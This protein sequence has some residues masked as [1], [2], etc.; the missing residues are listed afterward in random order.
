MYYTPPKQ[1]PLTV[2]EIMFSYDKDK[3]LLTK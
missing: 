2:K 1:L 3:D